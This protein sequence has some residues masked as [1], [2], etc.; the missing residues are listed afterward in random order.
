[1]RVLVTRAQIPFVR[2]GAE[3][4][5]DALVAALCE[6]G[7]EAELVALPFRTDPPERIL[8]HMLAAKLT[9]LGAVLGRPVDRVIALSFPSYFVAAP[10][11][12]LWLLHLHRAVYDLWEHA[13]AGLSNAPNGSAIRSAVMAADSR[14]LS[15]LERR[16]AISRRVGDRV[17]RHLGIAVNVLYPPI[18]GDG[19]RCAPAEPFLFFPSRITLLKRQILAARAMARAKTALRLVIAGPPDTPE[20]GRDLMA[21]IAASGGA[22]RIEYLGEI[23]EERK[24]D[25][26]ARCSA[27]LYPPFDEDYGYVTL[28]AMQSGKPVITCDDSGGPL[29]FVVPGVTGHVVPPDEDSIADAIA[30]IAARPGEAARMGEAGRG[31]LLE[32]DLTW[33]ATVEKLL[34]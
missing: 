32:L 7:H 11:K 17:Q 21:A 30:R 31:R 5:A 27:V 33:P 14:E 24:R 25:L 19:F 2:G 1:M 18:A 28:E 34:A 15:A 9:D 26:Y 8:D 12:T 23:D 20:N 3:I 29:E 13:Q 4:L 22:D 16:H 6:A 10:R